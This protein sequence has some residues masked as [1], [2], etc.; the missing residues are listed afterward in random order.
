VSV[1]LL[2]RC[3]MMANNHSRIQPAA[4]AGE[5]AGG[6]SLHPQALVATAWAGMLVFGIV[7]LLMGSLLPSL[8]VNDTQAGHLG[9]FPLAGI[10]LATIVVGPFLDLW[11]ARRILLLALALIAAPIAVMPLLHQYAAL[12]TAAF[13]YGLGGGLLNTATN[14]MVADLTISN[15]ERALNLLGAF[16]SLGAIAAPL[17]MAMTGGVLSTAAVLWLLA[18]LIALLLIP[19]ALLRFPPPSQAGTRM[20][21]LLGVLRHPAVWIFGILLF[22]ESG[23]ENTMFVW[24]GKMA[25]DALHVT[26]RQ[27]NFG[28]V[29]LSAALGAG[30]LAAAGW[31]RF[32]GSRNGVLLSCAVLLCG[33]AV[34][35]LAGGMPAYLTGL[36][37]IGA[38]MAAIF[39][40]TLAMASTRFPTQT[41]TVFGAIMAVALVGGTL[42]PTLSGHLAAHAPRAVLW[43]PAISAVAVAVF[44][45]LAAKSKAAT[46]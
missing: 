11:G 6:R 44:A 8:A 3:R 1:A 12:A 17:L 42:G 24:A 18:S 26:L 29:G 22:F 27:A 39:P 7:L 46:N 16:F 35:A 37:L 19:V 38:G 23:N 10:L 25:V 34:C 40:T 41:G 4:A 14:A 43:I 20:R 21:D 28:L 36:L 45:V 30:R 13:L 9:S 31:V 2:E 32:V 33:T 15:K 5:D